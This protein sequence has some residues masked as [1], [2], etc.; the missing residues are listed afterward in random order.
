MS[1]AH[2]NDQ[3]ND[4]AVAEPMVTTRTRP[5]AEPS[6]QTQRQPPYNVVILN[7]EEHTFLYV[8]ELLMKLFGHPLA[9]AQELTLTIHTTGR[10]VVYTGPRE[11]AELKADQITTVHEVREPDGRDLGPLG[12]EVEPAPGE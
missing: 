7:D 1:D 4:T 10:A 8:T 3:D 5:K 2:D 12:C 6:T 9:K 11:V